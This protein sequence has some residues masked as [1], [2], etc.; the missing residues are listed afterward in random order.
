MHIVPS[1]VYITQA[2]SQYMQVKLMT[3]IKVIGT[4]PC[5]RLIVG[6]IVWLINTIGS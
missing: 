6:T 1:D 5:N 2:T 3:F 4:V